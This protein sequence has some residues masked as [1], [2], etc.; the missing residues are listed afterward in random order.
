MIG[1]LV[2]FIGAVCAALF[3]VYWKSE[4]STVAKTIDLIPGPPKIPIL[5]TY[6]DTTGNHFVSNIF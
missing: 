1:S 4:H 2:L 5:G 3:Y 6:M